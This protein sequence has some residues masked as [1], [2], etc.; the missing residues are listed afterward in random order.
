LGAKNS[1]L[2]ASRKIV[3]QVPDS[4]QSKWYKQIIVAKAEIY[5][6]WINKN[7]K[8]FFKISYKNDIS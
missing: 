1:S 2:F 5:N 6:V 8:C 3:V 4:N 7:K